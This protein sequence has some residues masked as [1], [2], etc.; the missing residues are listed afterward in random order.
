MEYHIAKITQFVQ[1]KSCFWNRSLFEQKMWAFLV[2]NT[3]RWIREELRPHFIGRR[4][5]GRE[6]GDEGENPHNWS[7]IS[8][9]GFYKQS[10]LLVALFATIWC[11]H[12]CWYLDHL[13]GCWFTL[14]F[15]RSIFTF[16]ILDIPYRLP[17]PPPP[18]PPPH[19]TLAA[20]LSSSYL[21]RL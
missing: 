16:F 5:R 21:F 17:P 10:D 19:D 20:H 11:I 15:S 6:G 12:W 7:S 18:P 4:E 13:L 3:K 8:V 14:A 2:F 1:A 9:L